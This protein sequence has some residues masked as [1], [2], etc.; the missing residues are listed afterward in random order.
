MDNEYIMDLLETATD[1]LE[2]A[3]A[4]NTMTRLYKSS[5]DG[6]DKRKYDQYYKMGYEDKYTPSERGNKIR[7]TGK[8]I[9]EINKLDS[10]DYN[11]YRKGIEEAL[12]GKRNL[13]DRDVQNLLSKMRKLRAEK[14]N[15]NRPM[16]VNNH[17]KNDIHDK[18]NAKVSNESISLIENAMSCVNA[19]S[20]MLES[21]NVE[22]KAKRTFGQKAI[23][24]LKKL[25]KIIKDFIKSLYGKVRDLL[26]YKD[27]RATS[28]I[29]ISTNI[30]AASIELNQI[31]GNIRGYDHSKKLDQI[32]DELEKAEKYSYK[33]GDSIDIDTLATVKHSLEMLTKLIDKCE[34]EIEY[35]EKVNTRELIDK[36][37]TDEKNEDELMK[38]MLIVET[39]KKDMTFA[40]TLLNDVN[41]FLNGIGSETMS[42]R[43][44]KKI[45]RDDNAF[46]AMKAGYELHKNRKT[47]NECISDLLIEA[48]E[49]LSED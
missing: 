33:A 26:G 36:A 49:L 30:D 8:F 16:I 1:L 10:N 21:A 5:A 39:S 27:I 48:A 14:R 31:H 24:A 37:V 4:N 41:T 3:G 38:V 6:L 17:G 32:K 35:A 11:R 29:S 23:D 7:E 22:A 25:F 34:K 13:N 47:Q 44:A 40:K 2:S 46:E 12:S 19:Y 15:N 9:E 43:K 18:I 28:S 20:I 42:V 45:N